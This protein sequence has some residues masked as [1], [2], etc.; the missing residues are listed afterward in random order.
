MFLYLRMEASEAKLLYEFD[1]ELTGGIPIR[2]MIGN[3]IYKLRWNKKMNDENVNRK[4][5]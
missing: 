3:D 5:F 4:K 1:K 2:Q